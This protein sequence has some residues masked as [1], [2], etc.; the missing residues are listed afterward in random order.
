MNTSLRARAAPLFR[1]AGLVAALA[2]VPGV[3]AA[4]M[5]YFSGYTNGCFNCAAP[6][7]NSA[8]Q[9][10]VLG[11]LTWENSQ[12]EGTTVDG[13]LSIG[14]GASAQGVQNVDNFGSFYLTA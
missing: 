4:Q 7:D 11:G 2:A 9:S 13:N 10:D 6:A 3:A 14:N 1:V 8:Y 5:V 12:F